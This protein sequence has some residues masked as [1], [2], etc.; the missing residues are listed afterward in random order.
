M[1]RKKPMTLPLRIAPADL[2][3]SCKVGNSPLTRALKTSRLIFVSM[4]RSISEMPKRP[5]T[6]GTSPTPSIRSVMPKEKRLVPETVSVPMHPTRM[7]KQAMM[8]ALTMEVEERNMRTTM[9][10]HMREK[11]SGG[12]K[13]RAK[14]ARGRA[15]RVSPAIPIVPAMKEPKAEIPRARPAYPGAPSGTHRGR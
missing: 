14:S 8:R 13:R 1:P 7:P 10:R 5:M 2:A 9:P 11:Y 3:Q 4:L 6:T 15:R 12:P